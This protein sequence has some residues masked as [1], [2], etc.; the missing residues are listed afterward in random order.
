MPVQSKETLTLKQLSERVRLNENLSVHARS[1]MRSAIN[2]FARVCGLDASTILAD[3]QAIRALA[4]NAAWQLGELS[5]GSWANTLSRLTRALD[6][7][8]IAVHRRRNLKASPEWEAVLAPLARPD[9]D[10]LHRF[11][12]WC[13]VHGIPPCD[14][15]AESFDAYQAYLCEQSVLDNP[16]ERYNVAR[17]AWNKTI[18]VPGSQY[19]AV[20]INE[21]PA[22]RGLGWDA[23]PSNVRA[24][25]DGYRNYKLDND[26]FVKNQVKAD[27]L[28]RGPRKSLKLITVN[29]YLSSLR[30]SASRLV[31][32][33]APIQKFSTL[34]AFV[35]IETVIG[36]LRLLMGSRDLD[37]AR[38]ALHA[39]MTAV[40]SVAEFLGVEGD[41]LAELKRLAKT[42]RHSPTGMC[43]RNKVRLRQFE[44]EEVM[45]RFV[46]LPWQVAARM[47]NVKSPSISQ[48]L[49]MQKA[50]LLELL[51]HIPLRVKNAA[52]LRLDRHFQ[53]PVGGGT[54]N[55][56]LNI[57][58][59]EVKNDKAIDAEF[60]EETSAF[61]ARYVAVFRPVLCD[62]QS[63]ALFVS[64]DG[65][66]KGSPALA[67]QFRKFIRRELGLTLNIHLMRHLM[68]FAHLDAY[69][70]DYEGAR[71]LLG[72]KQIET[73]IKFYAGMETASAF[74][75]LDAVVMRLRNGDAPHGSTQHKAVE[76]L[77]HFL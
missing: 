7:E 64:R 31:E 6:T 42:V 44:N 73:T 17:R 34:S 12:G 45:R 2:T 15:S 26:P 29:N 39:L 65:G 50:V 21:A 61:L 62:G 67:K 72:H 8:G 53:T 18:A 33:G 1:E 27:I 47:E 74:R 19:V 4:K 25:I 40:L 54:G 75:R 35:E 3:P 69:P 56:R 23:F 22:W 20:P 52:S 70:G 63:S 57:P 14:V 76:D 24:E 16:R 55:W 38:P 66:Q 13:S 5:K 49:L 68:A 36:G 11:A 48:A 46:R 60:S 77:E 30:Q 28:L 10:T 59:G 58:K 37:E 41:H 51:L 71:Q 43:E 32:N 9:R